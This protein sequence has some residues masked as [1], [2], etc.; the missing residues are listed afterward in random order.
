[1]KSGLKEIEE[2][3]S[4][5]PGIQSQCWEDFLTHVQVGHI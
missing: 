4:P 2:T 5:G 1:M 3:S